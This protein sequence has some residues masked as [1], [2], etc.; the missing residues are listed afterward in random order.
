ME[1][2]AHIGHPA[3][4]SSGDSLALGSDRSSFQILYSLPLYDHR[5]VTFPLWDSVFS[6]VKYEQHILLPISTVGSSEIPD[7]SQRLLPP[8]ISFPCASSSKV[9]FKDPQSHLS[10]WLTTDSGHHRLTNMPSTGKRGCFQK[11]F[12]LPACLPRYHKARAI[13]QNHC[14]FPTPTRS[15]LNFFYFL[16]CCL[17]GGKLLHNAV[18]ISN[19]Q[20]KSVIII[21]ISPPS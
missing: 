2:E 17:I 11:F 18:P 15:R 13:F 1:Q 6:S 5:Q 19:V 14:K 12:L 20:H 7:G 8:L 21:H 3:G 4:L 10:C 9:P 16:I